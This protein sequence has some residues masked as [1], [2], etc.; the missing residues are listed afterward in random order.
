MRSLLK[1]LSLIFAIFSIFVF[2]MIFTGEKIIP[3][4]VTT[5]E[6]GGYKAPEIF[7]IKLY[8]AESLEEAGAISEKAGEKQTEAQ[9]NLL[10]IIPVKTATVTN[11]KRQ[12]VI[13]GG[14]IFGIKLYSDGVIIVDTDTISTENGEKN[15]AQIA[16]L[17]IGDIILEYN[18][19][20][21]ESTVQFSKLLQ[22]SKGK[23]AKIKLK[24]KGK[25]TE[26]D[27]TT[28][29]EKGTG[30][31]RAGLWV[32]D[33]TAGIGTV[34][35]Y[36][37]QNN[38]FG[39]LGHPICDV[40][41]GDIIPMKKG[42]MAEA[43]VNGFYKSSDGN[44]GELCGVLTGKTSGTLCINCETGIFGYT[45]KVKKSELV[46][47]AVRQ[48]VKSGTAQIICTVDN[49]E[50]Q[51]YDIKIVKIFSNSSA[52]NKDMIIEVTDKNLIEKTGGILQGMSG[53][54]IIQNG[55]L[56]GA[57]THVFVN[58]PKQGYAI[59]AERMLLTSVSREM[60]KE[61]QIQN[62]S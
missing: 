54:P 20:K 58:N 29:K 32:R 46:P 35:F 38:S 47:V 39:G 5:V 52:V 9:I 2:L 43:Y 51:Y 34:T 56:V 1:F 28:L 15:P 59:F 25:I 55:M 21:I 16:G 44:V 50:P 10:S 3:D 8:S 11:S 49:G 19:V 24:R 60:Q 6:D 37:P 13:P 36:N 33:S 22:D 41:T 40:D 61:L 12:Y 14:E 4:T 48:E 62:A 31:Y 23:S 7:G 27:F 30:K 26:I 53:S 57:V 45:E 18:G 42:E 17:Q